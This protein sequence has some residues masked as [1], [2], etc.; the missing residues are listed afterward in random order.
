MM[1]GD[2]SKTQ[3][4]EIPVCVV[5]TDTSSQKIVVGAPLLRRCLSR[6]ERDTMQLNA[7]VREEFT[8]SPEVSD[9]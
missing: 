7:F 8:E 9:S 6:R 4:F 2:A 1:E 3:G 5:S